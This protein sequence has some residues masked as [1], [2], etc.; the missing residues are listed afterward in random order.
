MGHNKIGHIP[1]G[2]NPIWYTIFY[3]FFNLATTPM[4]VVSVSITVMSY[5]YFKSYI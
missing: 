5:L 3:L 1:M 4:V 2:Y